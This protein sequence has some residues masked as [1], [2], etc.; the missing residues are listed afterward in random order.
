MVPLMPPL[1]AHLCLVS[2]LV[3]TTIQV[4]AAQAATPPLCPAPSTLRQSKPAAP[5]ATAPPI[6]APSDEPIEVLS[7]GATLDLD[8]D[9]SLKGDVD[10]RQGE[11]QLHAEDVE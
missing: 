6:T 8:G 5:P 9:A 2:L 11:R 10:L 7:D 4:A 1:H 3:A